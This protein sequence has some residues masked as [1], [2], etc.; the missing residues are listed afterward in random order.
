MRIIFL[1]SFLLLH[2]LIVGAQNILPQDLLDKCFDVTHEKIKGG[3]FKGQIL[4]GKRNGMGFVLFSDGDLFA[5]DFDHD[6]ITGMGMLIA[7]DEVGNCPDCKTYIGNWQK[8]KKS[9][10]GKCYSAYGEMIY[11]GQFVDDKP[12][13][14]YPSEN[15]NQQRSIANISSPDGNV[16]LGEIKEGLPDG[17]GIIMFN[18]G[19]L[20]QSSFKNGERK[21]IGLYLAY[22]GEWQT[23]NVKGEQCNVVSSSENYRIVD[24]SRKEIADQE[25]SFIMDC[26]VDAIKLGIDF[27]KKKKEKE[28]KERKAREE[29]RKAQVVYANNSTSGS[30]YETYDNA[31][32]YESENASS[33]KGKT[34]TKVFNCS[35][36][37][38]NG[39]CSGKNRCH[40]SK[41]C[42][43]CQGDG[44]NYVSGIRYKCDVCK[45][46]GKCK[47]C[48]GT[49][50]CSTCH[51]TGKK[52]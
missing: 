51:G 36:C 44:Y 21:G 34:H 49:G 6:D 24:K 35:V 30:G 13:G 41:K 33:N 19:D 7:S 8:G 43:Y 37:A 26:A 42:S 39:K 3:K 14:S 50:K 23:M 9:G 27:A 29:A 16:F 28:E 32:E 20:W 10:Y 46:S 15:V 45:G 1:T 12:A 17:F 47:Y 2:T 52:S 22:D 11:Q 48:N 18:N 25:F 40:G 4:K 38:G 5:G 31:T